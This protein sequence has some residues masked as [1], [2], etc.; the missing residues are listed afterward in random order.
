MGKSKGAIASWQ[1]NW[2]IL[3]FLEDQEQN[4][5]SQPIGF[6]KIAESKI[7]E[8]APISSDTQG[9]ENHKME[10]I[11]QLSNLLLEEDEKS[12]QLC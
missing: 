4:N 6:S 8:E 2:K 3:Q 10:L 5:F 7:L 11:D 1:S 12:L 9:N